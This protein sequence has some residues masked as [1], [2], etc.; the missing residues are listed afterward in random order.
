MSF[1]TSLMGGHHHHHP[2]RNIL[3]GG[4]FIVWTALAALV[5]AQFLSVGTPHLKGS[6][7]GNIPSLLTPTLM[8]KVKPLPTQTT[9]AKEGRSVASCEDGYLPVATTGRD[10]RTELLCVPNFA[11]FTPERAR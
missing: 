7:L 8:V 11:V 5:G 4:G 3:I 6:V 2:V 1:S 10:E 9:L